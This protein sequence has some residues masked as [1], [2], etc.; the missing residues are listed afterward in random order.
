MNLR[1]R[2]A[3]LAPGLLLGGCYSWNFTPT[4]S[5][6]AQAKP[7]DCALE[8][9]TTAPARPYDE[10]GILDNKGT[11]V[12][13]ADHFIELVRP[14]ACAAGGDA[15]LTFV[16]SEGLYIKGTVLRF[17]TDAGTTPSQSP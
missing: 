15:V 14:H 6:R 5:A 13:T 12:Y 2:F 9:L 1:L 4:T 7:P 3:L 16:N 8:I 17:R 10:L 11:N